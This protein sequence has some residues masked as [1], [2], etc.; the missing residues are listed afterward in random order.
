M[1]YKPINFDE[2]FSRFSDQWAPK[3]I[4]ELNNEYQFKLARLQGEFVWHN[5]TETDEVFIVLDG[6]MRIDFRDG[7]VQLKNGEMFVVPRGVDH[8]PFARNECRVMLVEPRGVVNTGN[9]GG[10]FTAEND[11]WI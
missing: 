6:E 4:S 11:D 10:E 1:K 2:K 7:Q 3:V 5:H 9:A 8:K